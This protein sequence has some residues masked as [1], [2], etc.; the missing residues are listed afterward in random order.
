MGGGASGGGGDVGSS[1]GE[2]ARARTTTVEGARERRRE[3][4]A[5]DWKNRNDGNG[6]NA[7]ALVMHARVR[8]RLLCAKSGES[9]DEVGLLVFR[10]TGR[11]CI[12]MEI[13]TL[14]TRQPGF[15]IDDWRL[16]AINEKIKCMQAVWCGRE[17]FFLI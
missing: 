12:Y 7:V 2:G 5:A 10:E 3:V 6:R 17:V 1:F 8:Q 16:N 14:R 15:R 9:I 4:E 13:T 11:H